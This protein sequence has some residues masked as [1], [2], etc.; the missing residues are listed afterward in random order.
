MYITD[1]TNK[2]A[3]FQITVSGGTNT[4]YFEELERSAPT[5]PK[6]CGIF[7]ERLVVAGQTASTSTVAYS[8]RLKPYDFAGASA[9]EIDV[10][11]IIV[12]IK[13]FRN[14]LIIFCKNSI[15]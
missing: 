1:G 6:V 13:V 4:Y 10:G 11:D 9:G 2:I 12:G 14:R 5:N 3:E 8:S 15:F 7:S